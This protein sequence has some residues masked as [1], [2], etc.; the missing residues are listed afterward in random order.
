[1]P[2]R[3]YRPAIVVGH[4]ETGAMDKVDGPVL[5]LPDDQDAA[6]PPAGLAAAGRVDL[7]DTNVVPVDYVAKAMDHLAHL[8]GR[9]GEAFHL[10]NPEPQSVVEMINRF[11]EAAG[12]P[13]SPPR[14]TAPSPAGRSG[15]LPGAAPARHAWS[16]PSCGSRPSQAAARPDD[17]PTRH[18]GGGGRPH[19]LPLDVRLPPHRAG[20]GRLGHRRTG[21]GVLLA[22]ALWS[23]W[24]EHLDTTTGRD[25]KT[26]CRPRRQARRD[27]RRLLRHRQGHRAQGRPGR[28]HPDPR[29]AR[30]GQARGDQVR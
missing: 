9:D 4:S 19:L 27:H 21:P 18:P 7:G 2:W 24:E 5:L 10:V 11:C 15:L 6:R 17:R 14:S 20:A 30:Q 29:R 1:M 23:F 16:T 13:G 3:V 12:A 22:R 8:P 28:R 25:H 26:R